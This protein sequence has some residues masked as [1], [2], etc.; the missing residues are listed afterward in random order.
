M[1]I[2]SSPT[3]NGARWLRVPSDE[4]W[5]QGRVESLPPRWQRRLLGK[6]HKDQKKD[7]FRANVELRESTKSLLSVR[8]PL[9]ASDMAIC[10]AAQMLARRCL[11]LAQVFHA[12]FD[13]R[14][15]IERVCSGQGIT[16]PHK[17]VKDGPALA[18]MTCSIWWRR[19]L[20]RHHGQTVEAAAIWL[21]IVSKFG[22]LYVSDERLHARQQQN[23]RNAA[24]LESTY[25]INE[26][27]ETFTLAE[28][29]QKGTGNKSVRRAELMTRIAGFERI[30]KSLQHSALFIT[31]TCPSRFHRFRLVNEGKVAVDNP[32]YDPSETPRTGQL[33]LT[34]IWS[35]IR[36]DLARQGIG[37]YGFRIAEPQHDGTPHW[38]LLLFCEGGNE[39]AVRTTLAKH[40]LKDS[41]NELGAREHRC[42]IKSI[43]RHRSAAGYVAKY[44][45]KNIDGRDV[46]NDLND[47]PAV[48]TAAR[49]EAWA[50]T[51]RVRQFQQ[52]GGPPVGVWRELRRVAEI[53]ADAPE[54]L[55]LAHDAVNKTTRIEGHDGP[56]AAWDQYC[57]AQGG[58]FCG[59][60]A[61]I[62]LATFKP[63]R[64]GQYGDEAA[65]KP[66]G[67][68]Y[69]A[70]M[71]CLAATDSK[72]G[73]AR[74][75]HWLID[76]RRHE[77]TIHRK[78]SARE[79]GG[80]FRSERPQAVA[81]W[82]CVNNCTLNSS[83]QGKKGELH[84]KV[85]ETMSYL[86]ENRQL[87]KRLFAPRHH[88][89]YFC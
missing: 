37:V 26:D 62:K 64:L 53:P 18:R 77:W 73:D 43:D 58:V 54:A 21:G 22:D 42:V 78:Q 12:A 45:A 84:L 40:A 35:H 63:E 29:A 44:V 51:W 46:G 2:T 80:L 38:H 76:S 59:R 83:H 81:P 70:E 3:V 5:T 8:I 55:K 28:L 68:V 41:P 65:P 79:P 25:A 31:L 85:Y 48:E 16:P 75:G 74:V 17:K 86:T 56:C 14:A 57:K 19:K 88:E 52:I 89:N 49:V 33:H 1:T 20:R 30:A 47:R 69:C 36:A 72:A 24:T 82:T 10:D 61:P 13:L 9:D 6:W 60:K 34:K 15:A 11:D 4:E 7:Y 67:V 71:P 66:Y 32:A 27:G 50:T 87:L 39:G 23:R